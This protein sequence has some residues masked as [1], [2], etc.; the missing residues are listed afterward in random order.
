MYI[1]PRQTRAET[2]TAGWNI[3]LLPDRKVFAKYL[4]KTNLSDSQQVTTSKMG[5]QN[6]LK[7]VTHEQAHMVYRLSWCY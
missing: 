7:S 6:Q 3:Q 1:R 2:Y 4:F 5:D